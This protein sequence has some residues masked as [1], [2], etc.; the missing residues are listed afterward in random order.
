MSAAD[1][2]Q[3]A[4]RRRRGENAEENAQAG[5]ATQDAPLPPPSQ[6]FAQAATQAV[7]STTLAAQSETPAPAPPLPAPLPAPQAEKLALTAPTPGYQ[8]GSPFPLLAAIDD[9][10]YQGLRAGE[11]DQKDLVQTLG[12][13]FDGLVPTSPAHK[14][15]G[16]NRGRQKGDNVDFFVQQ[17]RTTHFKKV[18]N[19]ESQ[20][21]KKLLGAAQSVLNRAGEGSGSRSRRV[22]FLAAW[23]VTTFDQDA[24]KLDLRKMEDARV[25]ELMMSGETSRASTATALFAIQGLLAGIS[26]LSLAFLGLGAP[27]A[28]GGSDPTLSMEPSLGRLTMVFAQASLVGSGLRWLKATQYVRAS[29][30]LGQS[31]SRSHL[32]WSGLSMICHAGCFFCCLLR[33]RTEALAASKNP[34]PSSEEFLD[35]TSSFLAS[36]RALFGFLGFLPAMRDLQLEVINGPG[37][38]APPSSLVDMQIFTL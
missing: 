28:N 2:E 9:A 21:A 33:G 37:G 3:P 14:P 4:R 38:L 20:G 36:M 13:T 10:Q 26:L 31:H 18:R 1:A 34:E 32:L 5:G 30:W 16:E 7:S 17:P 15:Q 35:S 25:F 29:Q 24:L 6:P 27:D 8:Q 11:V 12:D 23:R 19:S 22:P